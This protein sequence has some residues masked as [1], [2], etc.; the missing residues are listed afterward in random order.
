MIWLYCQVNSIAPT[1]IVTWTKDSVPLIQDTPHIRMMSTSSA[2]SSTFI[3]VVSTFQVSD[4]GVYQCTA[5]DRGDMA[6][7]TG[8]V[9]IGTYVQLRGGVDGQ[10]GTA[11]A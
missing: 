4:S 7:G 1:L 6:M 11:M 2:T 9:L 8:L 5:E 10:A 3:L